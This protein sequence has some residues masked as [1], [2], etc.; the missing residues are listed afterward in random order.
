MH[1]SDLAHVSKALIETNWCDRLHRLEPKQMAADPEFVCFGFF[2]SQEGHACWLNWT[3][4][5]KFLVNMQEQYS[6]FP[7]VMWGK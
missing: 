5:M 4:D 3:Y 7:K 1:E 2:S 6:N